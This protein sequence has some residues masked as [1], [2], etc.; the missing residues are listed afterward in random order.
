MRGGAE[1]EEKKNKEHQ[2]DEMTTARA[3]RLH[4]RRQAGARGARE[5]AH[6]DDA[7]DLAERR[8]PAVTRDERL[9]EDSSRTQS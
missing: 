7:A 1:G 8:A 3:T 6:V 9:R 4:R 2:Q 5:L